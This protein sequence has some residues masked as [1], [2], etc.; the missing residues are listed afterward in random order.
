MT[1][2]VF[3]YTPLCSSCIFALIEVMAGI[4]KNYL[5]PAWFQL[6]LSLALHQPGSAQL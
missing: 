1:F 5:D 2:A 3:H 4:A 6:A